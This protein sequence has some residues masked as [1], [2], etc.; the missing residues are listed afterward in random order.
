MSAANP[1]LFDGPILSV[2]GFRQEGLTLCAVAERRSYK[3]LAVQNQVDTGTEQL[4]V[5]AVVAGVDAAG[6]RHILLGRR[7][8][9][10]RIYGGMWE[11]GPSGGVDPPQP[12][13]HAVDDGEFRKQVHAEVE[14]EMG[15]GL[16]VRIEGTVAVVYDPVARSYD[17]V[18]RC[19][20]V[21][22]VA[23]AAAGADT[24]EYRGSRWL[25]E[26][27]V[28]AF[29][30]EHA[31]GIIGTTRALFRCLGWVPRGAPV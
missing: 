10:T 16:S 3:H 27:E 11:L 31:E 13:V 22:L 9:G 1:R 19:S 25:R 14:E 5:T 6:T 23:S 21:G 15:G 26:S 18:V 8:E 7:G 4:S 24:W 29:D 17:I 30:R 20:A 28:A 12:G 2:V